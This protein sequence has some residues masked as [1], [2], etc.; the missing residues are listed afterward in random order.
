MDRRKKS[1]GNKGNKRAEGNAIILV[2]DSRTRLFVIINEE[3]M[4]REERIESS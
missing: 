1:P 4:D 2:E 3:K